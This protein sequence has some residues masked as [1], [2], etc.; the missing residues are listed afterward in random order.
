MEVPYGAG[1]MISA[2][3]SFG[4]L[5]SMALQSEFQHGWKVDITKEIASLL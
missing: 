5:A 3:E 1:S 2:T 4:L